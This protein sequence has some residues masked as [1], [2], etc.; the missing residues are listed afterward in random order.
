MLMGGCAPH[1]LRYFRHLG[2]YPSGSYLA[3]SYSLVRVLTLGSPIQPNQ[4]VVPQLDI[5][6]SLA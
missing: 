6:Q 3:L 1:C 4:L 5:A 2:S